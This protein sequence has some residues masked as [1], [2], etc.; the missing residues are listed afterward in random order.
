[1]PRMQAGER[2]AL[3]LQKR[4]TRRRQRPAAWAQRE[5]VCALVVC[6]ERRLENGDSQQGD[7][8]RDHSVRARRAAARVVM[9]A[10]GVAGTC[11][12]SLS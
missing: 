10:P 3:C 12:T 11:R 6:E 4:E 1:M 9:L 7:S 2:A 8:A 5:Q